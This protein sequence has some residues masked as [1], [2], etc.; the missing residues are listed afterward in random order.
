[1]TVA[2]PTTQDQ[3]ATLVDQG[4][5]LEEIEADVLEPAALSDEERSALW[6]FAWGRERRNRELRRITRR[7][8]PAVPGC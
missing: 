4:M 6:L 7:R 1:M 2:T 8:E 5:P 3:I